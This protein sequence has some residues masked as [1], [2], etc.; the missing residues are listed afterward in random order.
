[1][2]PRSTSTVVLALAAALAGTAAAQPAEEP[3]EPQVVKDPK[4]VKTWQS[5]G[6]TLVKKGDAFA[7]QG[8]ADDAKTS[9][10]NAV[11]AYGKAI[12]ASTD[13]APLQLTLAHAQI[14]A[15]DLPAAVETLTALLATQ[16]LRADIS[17]KAQA[18]QDELS[19]KVGTVALVIVPD[20]ASVTLEGKHLGDAPLPAPLVLAPG[21]HVVSLA[22][23][24]YQPR[25]VELKVEA[26]SESE[27]K[28][29]LE[30]MPVVVKPAEPMDSTELSPPPPRG[31]SKLPL[32]NGAG[33]TGA[34]LITAT[35]TGI[36]AVGKHNQYEDERDPGKRDDLASQGKNLALVTDICIAGTVVAAGA[37]AY[38]YFYKYRPT[39]KAMAERD[40]RLDVVPWVQPDVG[41]LAAVGSF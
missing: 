6:D 41:G 21:T 31:P 18:L 22:A 10:D 8:K 37:T 1:M 34:L 4:V 17:K 15:D 30:P 11:T 16:G 20:G 33:A 39:A 32:Y 28:I 14:K 12:D 5:A 38:W 24:G 9:Y 13:P 40:V 26:G 35:I 27:R 25:D 3:V 36:A 29:E 23:A 7:K 2:G 19:M